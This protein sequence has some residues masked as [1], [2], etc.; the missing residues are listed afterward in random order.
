MTTINHH[1]QHQQQSPTKDPLCTCKGIPEVVD[2]SFSSSSSP[3]DL[4]LRQNLQ[5]FGWSPIS[6][7]MPLPPPTHAGICNLFS[8]TTTNDDDD[9]Y[10][11]YIYRA[12]ESGAQGQEE[13]G[14]EPKESLELK[15]SDAQRGHHPIDDWCLALAQIADRVC[16]LLELPPNT[17]LNSSSNN[18]S[19]NLDL[20]RVFYYRATTTPQ[21]GSSPHTD[22]GSWTIVWQDDVGGLETYC[23]SCHQWGVPVP[24]PSRSSTTTTTTSNTTS[25]SNTTFTWNCI[26]HV[27]DMASL[28][29]QQPRESTNKGGATMKNDSSSSSPPPHCYYWPSPKHRVVTSNKERASLVYF[30]YPPAHTSIR[31]IRQ[32]LQNWNTQHRGSHLPLEEYY[33][34]QD[35]SSTTTTTTN[36]SISSSS[37]SSSSEKEKELQVFYASSI[38]AMSIQDVIQEK[39]NQVQR[40]V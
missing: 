21:M 1:Q 25:S 6:M 3:G 16:L 18:N 22:W 17:L 23:R 28:A 30:G 13:H 5:H 31:Q 9:R 7:I 36:T 29:L 33:L 24:P 20:M 27:G 12:A 14:V 39:W 34:L 11:E 15:L 10:K 38:E 2:L 26:V 32:Q 19:N 4:L 8:S 40:T 35:Q 37:S